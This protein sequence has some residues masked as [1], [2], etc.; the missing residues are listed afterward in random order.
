[1][2]IDDLNAANTSMFNFAANSKGRVASRAQKKMNIQ[3]QHEAELEQAV[4]DG[5]VVRKWEAQLQKQP[6]AGKSQALLG[7]P[8]KKKDFSKY[9]FEDDTGR[10]RELNEEH[11]EIVD[12]L[13]DQSIQLRKQAEFQQFILKD[14]NE[15]ISRMTNKVSSH[16]TRLGYGTLLT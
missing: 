10:Q 4:E 14:Q 13:L 5:D 2:N 15:Q 6:D 9:E 12:G 11:D 3:R 16:C 8:G 1:M 7:A